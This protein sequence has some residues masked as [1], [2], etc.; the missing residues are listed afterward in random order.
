LLCHPELVEGPPP[1]RQIAPREGAHNRNDN[2]VSSLSTVVESRTEVTLL[3]LFMSFAVI[4]ATGFGGSGIPMM[5]REFVTR[6]G[7]LTEREFLDVYGIAQV[8]PGAIPV[9]LAVLIGRRLAGTA[10]F[11]TCLVAETV[12]GF[13]VLMLI[14]VLSMDPHMSMLRSA[15]K[16]CAAAAVGMMLG[17]ALQLTWPYR[18]KAVDLIIMVAVGVSVL[19]FHASLVV[20][21][22]IFIP[23]SIF[24]HRIMKTE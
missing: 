19:A 24:A 8:S 16:G 18:T 6:R 9:T 22:L 3:R 13:L 20:M 7:W 2:N 4:S 11:W 1:S 17:N 12:P 23:V 10:G 14:A 15:L 21:F 5:R